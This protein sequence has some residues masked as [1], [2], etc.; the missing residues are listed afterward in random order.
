M[1]EEIKANLKKDIAKFRRTGSTVFGVDD[2]S[3][4]IDILLPPSDDTRRFLMKYG[5]DIYTEHRSKYK[6]TNCISSR[7]KG[8]KYNLII[9]KTQEIYDSWIKATERMTKL[10][11]HNKMFKVIITD[12]ATRI[13]LFNQLQAENF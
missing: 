6:H 9:C 4:D 12:K 2:A 13:Q 5:T 1:N 3:S 11:R 10:L 7:I 8:T